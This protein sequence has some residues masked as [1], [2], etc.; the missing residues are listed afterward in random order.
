MC[1]KFFVFDQ[2]FIEFV[3]VEIEIWKWKSKKS[4]RKPAK[5][6]CILFPMHKLGYIA[7]Y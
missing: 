2:I 7:E 3:H 4:G 6:E 1:R 5:L